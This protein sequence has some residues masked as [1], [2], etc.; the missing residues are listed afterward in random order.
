[1]T[2]DEILQ[3]Q[4]VLNGLLLKSD[5][6]ELSK[7]LKIKIVRL[8]I[9]FNKVKKQFDE[10]VQ[11]FTKDLVPEEL[12]VLQSKPE[13]ERTKKDTKNLET[14]VNKVNEEYR[15]FLVQKGKEDV[16]FTADYTFS[17][18]DFDEIVAVN[19]G[20]DITVN[21]T[22]IKSEEFLEIFYEFF[23]NKH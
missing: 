3:K 21:N 23:V 13:D 2:I 17:E 22:K 12:K 7:E 14:L 5:T 16:A 18:K 19:A 8:R 20:A 9:A 1:M 4:N 10:D 11:E 15:E 6:E